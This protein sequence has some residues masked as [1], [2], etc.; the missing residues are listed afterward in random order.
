MAMSSAITRPREKCRSLQNTQSHPILCLPATNKGEAGEGKEQAGATS[1]GADEVL[2]RRG[3]MVAGRYIYIYIYMYIYIMYC[4][5]TVLVT[6]VPS[7]S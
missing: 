5:R 6:L 7:P 1:L 4:C 2:R 3:P